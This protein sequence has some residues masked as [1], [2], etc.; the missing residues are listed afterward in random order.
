MKN[1]NFSLGIKR[2]PYSRMLKSE[3]ADYVEKT[4]D[5]V[6]NYGPESVLVNPVFQVLLAKKPEINL[7]RLSYGIDTE[8][9]R[10]NKLKGELMLQISALKLK[11]RLL[12]K[13]NLALDMHVVQNAINSH[14]SC[15]YDCRNDKELNQ[16]IAGFFDLIATN[17]EFSEALEEFNL[18]KEV[19]DIR[20]AYKS[21]NAAWQKRVK[22]L[23]QRPT[24]STQV[25]IKDMSEAI[26]NLFKG[27]EVSH[28]VST[29]AVDEMPDEAKDY[30]ALIDELNQLSEMFYKSISI[31]EA[32]NKR[33]A[34]LDNTDG[35][36]A[37]DESET[38]T[39]GDSSTAVQTAYR[40]MGSP[41]G[42]ANRDEL[43]DE[44]EE[45]SDK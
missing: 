10:A 8:R 6:E 29:M 12:S 21:V 22:M 1:T 27:L 15:L 36:G 3:V 33:K 30:S 28:L 45:C 2:L 17:E 23:S 41:L 14:L 9:L 13:S 32:N 38:P 7:L 19:T 43:P 5:V 18:L 20:L 31:R 35:D 42:N 11:V 39:D 40:T 25:I 34:K 44:S 4:I 24:I 37:T 26:D 16:K